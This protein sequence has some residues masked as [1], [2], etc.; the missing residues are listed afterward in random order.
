M[1]VKPPAGE[2]RDPQ[3]EPRASRPS[4][5][6]VAPAAVASFLQSDPGST[7]KLLAIIVSILRRVPWLWVAFAAIVV[8]ALGLRLYGINWDANNHLHPDEREIVFRA[9]CLSFPNQVASRPPNC[10]PAVTGAGWFFSPASP[11]NPHFFAYG[12]LPLYLLAA[13]CHGL[14]WLTRLTDGRF[15]PI[16]G[17]AWD[18]FNHFTLVGRFLSALFDTG[19]VILVGLLGRRLWGPRVGL[20][21]AALVAVIPFEVQVSHYYAV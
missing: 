4:G 3:A 8:A 13:V 14:A 1:R 11:L 7:P 18:D 15:V 16:D 6:L 9:M 17:G 2:D 19:S 5:M 20:L 21:A 12:S 10:D